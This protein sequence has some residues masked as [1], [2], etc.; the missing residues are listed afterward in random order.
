MIGNEKNFP[1][2][3]QVHTVERDGTK[4]SEIYQRVAG[5]YPEISQ[6]AP[7]APEIADGD[8]DTEWRSERP[9]N[10]EDSLIFRFTVPTTLSGLSLAPGEDE[11]EYAR[12]PEVSISTDGET[13]TPL[14]LT[15]SGLFDLTFPTET[16]EWLRIRNTEHADFHWSV[17]EIYF[18]Q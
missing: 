7:A 15:I 13:W 2:Y 3:D 14:P 6:I 10:P 1:L 4:L 18:Y 12:S 17:R 16:T 5:F 11:N 9:Q 8:L